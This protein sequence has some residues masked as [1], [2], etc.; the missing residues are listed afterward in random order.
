MDGGD[1]D[2]D[3]A[4]HAN[5]QEFLLIMVHY[6]W[7]TMMILLLLGF[8]SYLAHRKQPTTRRK[9][10]GSHHETVQHTPGLLAHGGYPFIVRGLIG[11]VFFMLGVLPLVLIICSTVLGLILAAVE[12]WEAGIGVEYVLSNVLGMTAP[13]TS[14]VPE[15]SFGI[16]FAII[17]NMYA[18][19]MVTTAMGLVANMSLM[20]AITERVPQGTCGFICFLFFV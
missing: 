3:V 19:V 17:L 15:G 16:H 7:I 9:S 4:S 18:V 14:V 11:T 10:V 8:C 2:A 20:Q 13:L 12:G 6:S 5:A 1:G